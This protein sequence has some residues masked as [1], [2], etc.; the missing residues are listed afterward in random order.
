[1]TFTKYRLFVLVA[2][3]F[4]IFTITGFTPT[5]FAQT[6]QSSHQSVLNALYAQ[7]INLRLQLT[8]LIS[9][10]E[11]TATAT[12]YSFG[13]PQELLAGDGALYDSMG[14]SA[15]ISGV[16]A[17]LGAPNDS[18]AIGAYVGSAYV[19]RKSGSTWVQQQKLVASDGAA[20]DS[21]GSSVSI[22]GDVVV[23]GA[24]YDDDRGVSSGSA[25]IF[26]RNE[27]ST[28]TIP[29]DDFW[30]QK[31]KL[32]ASDG[33]AYDYFGISVGISGD[34][35]IV[36][37]SQG[38]P[39]AGY[40]NG[41]AYTYRFNGT[42]WIEEQKLLASD[43]AFGDRFGWSVAVYG[44]AAL[45]GAYL[46]ED[47]VAG[48]GSVY[49]F[50]RSGPSW[51][52]QQKLLPSGGPLLTQFGI[53]VAL[54]GELAVVGDPFDDD[55][56]VNFGSASL[57]RFNGSAWIKE[58][59]LYGSDSAG[60][61]RFGAAV[62]AGDNMTVIGA[63]NDGNSAPPNMDGYGAL[64]VFR[65]I[66]ASWSQSQKISASDPARVDN[67]AYSIGFS[68]GSIISGAWNHSHPLYQ[69][70][71][72]YVYTET[73][74]SSV[75]QAPVVN[76]GVDQTISLPNTAALDGTV[77]DDG[78]PNPPATITTTWSKITGPG[79]VTFEN[80]SAVDT[81]ASFSLAGNYALMLTAND[82]MGAIGDQLIVTVN[83]AD[84]TTPTIA[85]V[86]PTNNLTTSNRYVG[87]S[88][89]L[90]DN[91]ALKEAKLFL[92]NGLAKTQILTGST[93]PFSYIQTT[94]LNGGTHTY[95]LEVSDTNNNFATTSRSFTVIKSTFRPPA[96]R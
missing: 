83:P 94:A 10:S 69:A 90:A 41:A 50:R 71:A 73:N 62:A 32:T 42:T 55:R 51:T 40:G 28:P 63:W 1:M 58:T 70:G 96:P 44:D 29:G 38:T 26:K 93:T 66:D 24:A 85:N 64:Y 8:A 46:D 84:A 27:N 81:T 88:A 4:L 49:V 45:V 72:A 61:G 95:R 92:D 9:S 77:S 16:Y 56:G 82:G 89:R 37:V 39:S 7:L 87:F 23:V 21:F 12:T 33:A 48:R 17:V 20:Y 52:Q 75:N 31:Q 78:L 68:N 76:A 34:T 80:A 65:K 2:G 54:Y 59:E 57:F 86:F 91:V 35:I 5:V 43:G 53:S 6:S 36:G 19:F 3:L 22:D 74:D 60:N 13:P 67:F 47:A 30:E 25:Y 15:A 14:K 18:S 11:S 79:T